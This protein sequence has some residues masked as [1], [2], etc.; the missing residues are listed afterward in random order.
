M[1]KIILALL[2]SVS[3]FSFSLAQPVQ[4]GCEQQVK[5]KVILVGDSWASFS[6][7]Y[8]AFR[9]S[10]SKFGHDDKVED[11]LRTTM[12]GGQ[13]ESFLDPAIQFKVEQALQLHKDAQAVIIFLGGNDVMSAWNSG[14]NFDN[15]DIRSD[16]V[17]G[18]MLQMITYIRAARPDIRIIVSSYDYPNFI[19]PLIEWPE[20]PYWDFWEGLGFP[21]PLEANLALIHAEQRRERWCDSIG[22]D[23]LNN[24]GLM[25]YVFGQKDPL[26]VPPYDTYLPRTVPFPLGDPRY[27]S[28]QEAMGLWGIDAYHLGPQGYMEIANNCLKEYLLPMFRNNP[29]ATIQSDGALDGWVTERGLKGGGDLKV[30]VNQEGKKVKGIISFNTADLPDNAVITHASLFVTKKRQVGGN[31]I[32]DDIFPS[33]SHIDIKSGG[34]GASEIEEADYSAAADMEDAG[35]FVGQA[36]K[37]DYAF[38][39]DLKPEALQFVNTSGITQLRLQFDMENPGQ[40]EMGVYY[41]GGE[42]E[43]FYAPYLDIYYSIIDGEND[44]ETRDVNSI[45]MYPNPT[46]DYIMVEGLAPKDAAALRVFNI[47]GSLMDIAIKQAGEG[48]YSFDTRSFAPGAYFI[49]VPGKAGKNSFI[50]L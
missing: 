8:K 16:E 27:P 29:D 31:P 11:G 38:R 22:V 49:Q 32:Q 30:G 17:A 9:E 28:P 23:Y 19:E 13:A 46:A 6:W 2:I 36:N 44:N 42:T 20:N 39:V 35:C 1:K 41:N 5:T 48:K 7:T 4:N 25:Q 37:N 15:L 24:L 34:F 40:E 14:E 21:T 18:E 3:I 33:N 45:K 43:P 50:K 10:L 12:I 47:T 26:P